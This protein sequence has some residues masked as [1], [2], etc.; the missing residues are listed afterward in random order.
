MLASANW[1]VRALDQR[2]RTIVKVAS[3]I[4]K[5]QEGVFPPRRIASAPAHPSPDRRR[6][7]DA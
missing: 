1:L 3:E 2:Q 6:D 4:V 7:R 5:Q